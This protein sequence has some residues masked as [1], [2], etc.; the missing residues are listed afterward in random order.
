MSKAGGWKVILHDDDHHHHH[1]R[2]QR[3]GTDHVRAEAREC[4]HIHLANLDE[5]PGPC[6]RCPGGSGLAPRAR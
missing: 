2:P 6:T 3:E 4:V 5:M 1:H